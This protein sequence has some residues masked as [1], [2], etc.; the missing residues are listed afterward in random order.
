MEVQYILLSPLFDAWVKVTEGWIT[1]SLNESINIISI[2]YCPDYHS[3]SYNFS[4]G[5]NYFPL[6]FR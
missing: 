3:R 6:F 4:I 1:T 2:S 5:K